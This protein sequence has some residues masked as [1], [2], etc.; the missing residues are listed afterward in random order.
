MPVFGAVQLFL[1]LCLKSKPIMKHA[2]FDFG[3]IFDILGV[4]SSL[5]LLADH[6]INFPKAHLAALVVLVLWIC[7][8]VIK[9]Q[10]AWLRK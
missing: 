1:Y 5:F 9:A 2:S 8:L 10:D 3:L 4:L 7:H 6:N